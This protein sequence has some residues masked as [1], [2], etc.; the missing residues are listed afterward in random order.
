VPESIII[1]AAKADIYRALMAADEDVK[2]VGRT[3]ALLHGYGAVCGDCDHE[4][5]A[6]IA[7][8]KAVRRAMAALL[9]NLGHRHRLD[10]GDYVRGSCLRCGTHICL[11]GQ[12]PRPGKLTCEIR[13]EAGSAPVLIVVSPEGNRVELPLTMDDVTWVKVLKGA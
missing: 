11:E 6:Q 8:A 7:C 3:S 2:A 13:E 12:E 4:L 9:G 10:D 5:E 1:P